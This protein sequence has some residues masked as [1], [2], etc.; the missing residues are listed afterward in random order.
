MLAAIAATAMLAAAGFA[1][2]GFGDVQLA[3]F[4]WDTT[5]LSANGLEWGAPAP[6]AVVVTDAR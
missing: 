6:D 1:A 3:S 5:P 2:V 4:G